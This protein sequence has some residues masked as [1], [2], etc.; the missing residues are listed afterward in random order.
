[1][2]DA[3]R[4]SRVVAKCNSFLLDRKSTLF[5]RAEEEFSKEE[6]KK[7]HLNGPISVSVAGGH[8]VGGMA[9]S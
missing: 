7:V 8:L 2:S 1:M 3:W 6:K 9:K 5:G 4:V